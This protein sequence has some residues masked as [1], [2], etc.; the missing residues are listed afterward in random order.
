MNHSA[1]ESKFAQVA[2]EPTDMVEHMPVIRDYS[3]TCRTVVEFGV[4]DCTSTWAL[5]AGFPERLLSV[6]VARR[7]EVDEVERLAPGAGVDFKFVLASSTAVELSET[8]LLFIDSLH[9]YEHLKEEL[10]LHAGKVR[11]FIILHDTTTFACNDE[12]WNG[13]SY[14]G[15]G[16][17]PAVEEFLAA[18]RDWTLKERRTNC[19][20]LTVLARACSSSRP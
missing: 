18:N 12:T 2:A 9:T 1:V 10:R 14:V 20:G 16:L 15:R 11:R 13:T 7:A 6:D 17:W 8:D 19:H 5:L 3:S 4:Y